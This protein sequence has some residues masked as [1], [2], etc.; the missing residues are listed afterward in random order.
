MISYMRISVSPWIALA[1]L[2]SAP[3]AHA[4]DLVASRTEDSLVIERISKD[5]IEIVYREPA[6]DRSGALAWAWSDVRT[7]WVVRKHDAALSVTR[8]RELKAEPP[9]EI[10]LADFQLAREPAQ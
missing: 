5:T 2:A 4:D 7:L 9:R 1:V 10:T 3:A 6:A 8:I